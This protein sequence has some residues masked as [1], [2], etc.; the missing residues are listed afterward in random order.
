M[1]NNAGYVNDAS[2][3]FEG[4]PESFNV[5]QEVENTVGGL[6]YD[7]YRLSEVLVTIGEKMTGIPLYE[8]QRGLS[9]RIIYS[10]LARD[11][12]EITALFSRQSGKS[13]VIVFCVIVLGILLPV[14]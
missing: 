14:S 11:G 6:V 8:Y 10:I 1:E 3:S 12:A 9:F 4:N 5:E 7:P 2:F 13:E